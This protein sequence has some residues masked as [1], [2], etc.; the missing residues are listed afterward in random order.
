M[1][2]GNAAHTEMCRGTWSRSPSR[3]EEKRRFFPFSLLPLTPH[4]TQ[5]RLSINLASSEQ[6]STSPTPRRSAI[7]LTERFHR[8]RLSRGVNHLPPYPRPRQPP[9]GRR[10]WRGGVESSAALSGRSLGARR[11]LPTADFLFISACVS[12][13]TRTRERCPEPARFRAG[14]IAIFAVSTT[15]GNS[16]AT[17]NFSSLH[18][19]SWRGS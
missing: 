16:L 5:H 18:P 7:S 3:D 11:T 10:T 12:R 2:L 1:F 19:G 6:D 9:P 4:P 13:G 15:R 17:V 8:V 14:A